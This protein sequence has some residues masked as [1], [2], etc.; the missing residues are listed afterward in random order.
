MPANS[1]A[2]NPSRHRLRGFQRVSSLL[3]KQIRGIGETRGFPISR[4]LT[5][6]NEIVGDDIGR[7]ARP[8]DVSYS[9]DGLGATLT[10]LTPGPH[11]PMLSMKLETIRTRVNAC[12]GYSAISRIRISQTAPDDF[13]GDVSGDKRNGSP[14]QEVEPATRKRMRR[15]VADISD[16]GL[17]QALEVFGQGVLTNL[18]S[19]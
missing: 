13:K 4:L 16:D 9:K 17:R 5:H 6:W 11:A 3:R 14:M 7:I 1:D 10:L 15:Q 18:N 8:M 12:Y 19:K 2:Y